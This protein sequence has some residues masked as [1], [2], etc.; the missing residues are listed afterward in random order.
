M[1]DLQLKQAIL[2]EERGEG[3]ADVGSAEDREQLRKFYAQGEQLKLDDLLACQ[4]LENRLSGYIVQRAQVVF[5]TL[6]QCQ[7]LLL[8][9][10]KIHWVCLSPAPSNKT[11]HMLYV[12]IQKLFPLLIPPA[13]VV[14]IVGFAPA[15]QQM[16]P[17]HSQTQQSSCY[18]KSSLLNLTPP[19]RR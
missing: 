19:Q 13:L 4:D 1:L 15:E 10:P 6:G 7:S 12:C 3:P 8:S 17:V 5:A 18:H 11:V 2:E 14:N 16:H 9:H